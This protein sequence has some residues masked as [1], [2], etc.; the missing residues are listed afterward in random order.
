MKSN[1]DQPRKEE[2]QNPIDLLTAGEAARELRIDPGTLSRWRARG[3]GPRFC[4]FGRHIRYRRS[5]V[6]RWIASSELAHSENEGSGRTIE[7]NQAVG[8]G[9]KDVERS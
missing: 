2:T 3:L 1:S 5:A 4:R 9:G 7:R 6:E 8:P